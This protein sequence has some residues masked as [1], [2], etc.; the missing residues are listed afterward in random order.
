MILIG[1]RDNG[2]KYCAVINMEQQGKIGAYQ[3]CP[4]VLYSTTQGVK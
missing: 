1:C 4:C 3:P 2:F